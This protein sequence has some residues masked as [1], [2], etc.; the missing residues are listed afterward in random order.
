MENQNNVLEITILG[1]QK[2][3]IE[4]VRVNGDIFDSTGN[5]IERG[6]FIELNSEETAKLSREDI[7]KIADLW[8]SLQSAIGGE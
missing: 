2:I 6:H 3:R 4:S 1:G 7:Q 8:S 5:L